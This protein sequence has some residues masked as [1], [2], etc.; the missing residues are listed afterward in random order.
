MR[1]ESRLNAVARSPV[2]R[3]AAIGFVLG[4]FAWRWDATTGFTGLM[5]FGD[6]NAARR[7]PVL[8]DLPIA[9]SPRYGYDGQFYAQIAVE[10]DVTDP[11]LAHALDKPSYRPRRILLP[12]LAHALGAGRP[13]VVLQVFALLHAAAW[14]WFAAVC[15]RLLPPTDWR[16]TA[17]WLCLVLGVGVLD[18][19]RLTLT[20]LPAALLLALAARAMELGR[21]AATAAWVLLAG[22]TREVSLAGAL[23]VQHARGG[24]RTFGLRAAGTAPVLGWCAWLAW[25][26]PGPVGHEGNIDWPGAAF[27]RQEWQNAGALLTGSTNPGV[28]FGLIGG[29]GLAAQSLFVL[30][31][32]RSF[33]SNPWVRIGLPF[34]VLF[35]L[36]GVDP[37]LDYRA[38][39]RDCLPM[40]LVFNLLWARRAGA[41]PLWLLANL[42]VIDGVIRFAPP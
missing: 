24:W 16:A 28:V 29:I 1:L 26:L 15:W 25:R 17:A 19:V 27:V 11:A 39:A 6:E 34:A 38:V 30:R 33:A 18:C 37:W 8:Q 40:T 13:W 10:P 36:I 42:G 22:L 3:L 4:F 12:L 5:R 14:L 41:H 21:P 7:L 2:V 32:W 23:V 20:D 9:G 31:E 35:W